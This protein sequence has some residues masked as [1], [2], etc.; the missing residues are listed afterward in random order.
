MHFSPVPFLLMSRDSSVG[1][2]TRLRTEQP[3][4]R[5]SI[6]GRGKRFF[7]LRPTEPPAQSVPVDLSPGVKRPERE[8]Y[9]SSKSSVEVKD[10]GAIPPLSR[11]SSCHS[12]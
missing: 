11:M 10:V 3:T 12:A 6:F 9:H 7:S 5:C 8:S 2:A 4:N 1:I